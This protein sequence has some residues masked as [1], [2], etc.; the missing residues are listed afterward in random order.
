MKCKVGDLA[1]IIN[2]KAGNTGKMVRCIE[3][4]G[5]G[6]FVIRHGEGLEIVL[7]DLGSEWWRLDR[8]LSMHVLYDNGIC[9]VEPDYAP[10][11]MDCDLMPIKGEPEKE[12]I[13]EVSASVV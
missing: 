11:A 6:P 5:R 9:F 4:L 12:T 8:K 7:K 1:L 13:D 3:C 10:F 2:S